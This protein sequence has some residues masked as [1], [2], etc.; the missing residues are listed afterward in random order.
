VGVPGPIDR[1]AEICIPAG[2]TI[3]SD[4]EGKIVLHNDPL[5]S[6]AKA[7]PWQHAAEFI[8]G[9]APEPVVLL[10][11]PGPPIP[12]AVDLRG[13]TTLAQAAAIIA[14]AKCYVGIESGLLHIA[15][16]LQ[17]PTVGLFGTSYIPAYS[18]VYPY[19]PRAIYVQAEGPLDLIYPE[20]VLQSVAQLLSRRPAGPDFPERVPG[21]ST[22]PQ[23]M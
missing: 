22:A 16:A 10:G 18:A 15:G 13:R 21:P 23:R 9:L 5:I 8:R 3:P 19:N 2:T 14:G 20:P 11:R 4:A 17:A 1:R 12:G 6:Q 7:W